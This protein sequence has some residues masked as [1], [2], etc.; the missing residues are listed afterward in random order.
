[1]TRPSACAL[2]GAVCTHGAM[3]VTDV[4]RAIEWMRVMPFSQPAPR[5]RWPEP[6]AGFRHFHF[7]TFVHVLHM[8][9]FYTWSA[10]EVPWMTPAELVSASA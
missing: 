2:S 3:G 8:R 6:H 5:T 7:L 9:P 1:M 10:V 4:H